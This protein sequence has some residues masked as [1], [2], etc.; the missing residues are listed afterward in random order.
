[1]FEL[2]ASKDIDWAGYLL[3]QQ[4]CVLGVQGTRMHHDAHPDQDIFA[5]DG[6]EG[7][8]AN[9]YSYKGAQVSTR[10]ITSAQLI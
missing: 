6:R 4:R 3:C 1:M 8:K 10:H 9:N 2:R 7:G 5:D